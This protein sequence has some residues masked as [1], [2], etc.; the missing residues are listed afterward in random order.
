[1][2]NTYGHLQH[3]ATW[4]SW[5]IMHPRYLNFLSLFTPFSATFTTHDTLILTTL[6]S[7]GYL[8]KA[9]TGKYITSAG[10]GGSF[11][12]SVANCANSSWN[13]WTYHC[14]SI[15]I[16]LRGNTDYIWT[17]SEDTIQMSPV[18]ISICYYWS[19][20]HIWSSTFFL[21]AIVV[22]YYTLLQH[23]ITSPRYHNI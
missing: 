6:G 13:V 15:I 12:E 5:L 3:G 4:R 21:A 22:D 11:V 16:H 7:D 20:Q 2:T 17:N 10:H 8:T 23:I 9:A 14:I 19:I 1:M 18:M